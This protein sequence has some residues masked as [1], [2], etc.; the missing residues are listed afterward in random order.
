M[1]NDDYEWPE[2][3]KKIEELWIFLSTENDPAA[4]SMIEERLEDLYRRAEVICPEELKKYKQFNETA[5]AEF[6][7]EAE[8]L[9]NPK[10]P[11][12]DRLPFKTFSWHS[13]F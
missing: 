5:L 7:E 8:R 2:E 9:F 13:R 4:R 3:I 11:Q 12:Q 1:A 10:H 6:V